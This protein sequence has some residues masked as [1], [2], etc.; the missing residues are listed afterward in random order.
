MSAAPTSRPRN[1][2]Q[3]ATRVGVLG[4][5]AL[6]SLAALAWL[7]A[8]GWLD[9]GR[10]SAALAPLGVGVYP[11]FALFY[12]FATML[13][14]PGLLLGVVA[15][16]L[17]HPVVAVALSLTGFLLGGS[18]SFLLSRGLGRDAMKRWL[19]GN[20]GRLRRMSDH[21]E[22]NAFL[23]IASM[24][25]FGAP[26]N[27][28]SYLSGLAGVPWR[29]YIYAS[30]VGALPGI[31]VATLTGGS[32]LIV[33]QARSL[34]ALLQPESLWT[35]GALGVTVL[36]LLVVRWRMRASPTPALAAE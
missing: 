14:V 18:G 27:V 12:A 28:A 34:A 3:V 21:F 30:F 33:L 13:W 6:G 2:R 26:N 25:L 8:S 7:L 15:M 29:T 4:L 36:V 20:Q 31:T 24:R 10:L 11:A 22:R 5:V 9:E 17:F 35:L 23:H 19:D 16:S 1:A 32:F